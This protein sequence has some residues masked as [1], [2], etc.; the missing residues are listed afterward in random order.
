MKLYRWS[1][2]C[3]SRYGDGDIIVMA[4]NVEEARTKAFSF[5][6]QELSNPESDF[7]F[8]QEEEQIIEQKNEFWNDIKDIEPETIEEQVILI[9]GSD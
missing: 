6:T 5:F 1:S 8:Y 9:K 3:L 7:Y 2:S 4:G